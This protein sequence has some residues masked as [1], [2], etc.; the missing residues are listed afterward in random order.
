MPKSLR[1]FAIALMVSMTTL[2]FATTPETLLIGPGDTLH[3]QVLDTPELEQHPRVTDAGEIPL[4]GIG[5]LKVAGLT[6][7]R[8]SGKDTRTPRQHALHEP[9]G[10]LC[11]SGTIR[12][13]NGIRAGTGQG[14]PALTRSRP[15]APC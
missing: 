13:A 14:H 12:H 8:R 5:S 3:V 6:P 11:D 1:L 9:S 10:S 2:A 4:I 15:R 7:A